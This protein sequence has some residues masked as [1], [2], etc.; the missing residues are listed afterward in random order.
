MATPAICSG[1]V[2][3]TIKRRKMTPGNRGFGRSVE[4]MEKPLEAME[5]FRFQ[6]SWHSESLPRQINSYHV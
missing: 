6:T 1:C 5:K 3:G 2:R 4:A